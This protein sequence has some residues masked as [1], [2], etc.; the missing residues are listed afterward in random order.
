MSASDDVAFEPPPL[1]DPKMMSPLATTFF[2]T[3]SL[4]V[5]KGSER[6]KLSNEDVGDK[7]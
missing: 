3:K 7:L 5:I 1:N 2:A 4:L 6:T